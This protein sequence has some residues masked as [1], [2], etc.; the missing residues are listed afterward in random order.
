[1]TPEDARKIAERASGLHHCTIHFLSHF[2][3]LC[4]HGHERFPGTCEV[5]FSADWFKQPTSAYNP[6]LAFAGMGLSL[7]T[8]V[9][10]PSNGFSYIQR[11]LE[12][13]K[14][15]DI[16]IS[17][18]YHR[19][20]EDRIDFEDDINLVAYGLGH[21]TITDSTGAPCELLVCVVRG[22]SPTVEWVSNADV[23]DSV[24]DGN[25]DLP[26]HEGFK[27]TADEAL[28][29]IGRYISEHNI[30]TSTA[31]LWIVGH[32]RGATIV[33]VLAA[34]LNEGAGGLGFNK[35]RIFAY[36]FSSSLTTRRADARTDA[37][38]NIFNVINPEDYI[39]RIPLAT[40]G[41]TRF[42]RDISL[43]SIC[44]DYKNYRRFIAGVYEQ[45]LK[46]TH[47]DYQA[48]HGFGATNRFERHAGNISRNVNVMY[49]D[50]RF[51]HGG[52][53]TF[54]AYFRE[55]CDIAG[56]NGIE[57][58]GDAEK[59]GR[60]AGGPFEH[61]LSYFVHNQIVAHEAP[62]AHQEEGYLA[63][64]RACW[65]LGIDLCGGVDGSS[66][67]G[68]ADGTSGCG[69]RACDTRR[70]TVYGPVD[71]D[72]FNETGAVVASIS[73]HGIDKSLYQQADFLGMFYDDECDG[74][75]VWIPEEGR[76]TIQ[77]KARSF[78]T[79]DITWA[80]STPLGAV[81]TQQLFADVELP[82][83]QAVLWEEVA[84]E[85][86]TTVAE[87]GGINID[88]AVEGAKRGTQCDAMGVQNAT[89]GEHCVIHAY[90]DKDFR[91]EGWFEG[92]R[93]VSPHHSYCFRVEQPR[94][95][96]ARFAERF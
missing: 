49:E 59:L 13:F 60:Y 32:S 16:D 27:R 30:D 46:W 42:G 69:A 14:L 77:L 92:G 74:R 85:K 43:P 36:T 64:M 12:A 88:V 18:Y 79:F 6:G 71:I 56:K 24:T 19:N 2:R 54:A 67:E 35:D 78:G 80:E 25:C 29:G 52:P 83:H 9:N 17:S 4:G 96:T 21:R 84:P 63:K 81:I 62:G 50:A 66:G 44:T 61:F 10:V 53:L 33:N 3:E 7:S 73:K 70:F 38:D 45:F 68:E 37:F 89:A 8:Y 94:T 5:P 90:H 72:V 57:I 31:R 76:Y 39:P 22:T 15:E 34:L 23:A 20:A 91:F 48:F 51:S 95:L 28:A 75:S 47:I 65:E 58:A 40:W 26:Y 1:M 93:L 55:F 87:G 11:S 82:E 86:P 41:Y